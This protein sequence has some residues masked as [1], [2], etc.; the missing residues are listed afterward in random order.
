MSHII[1]V[2]NLVKNYKDHKAVRNV[3]FNVNKGEVFGFLGPNGAGKSTTINIL[4]TIISLSKGEVYLDG[5]DVLT[6][7]DEVRKKIGI[8]FQE[9]TLD[10]RLTARENLLIHA[11]LYDV[12]ENEI[13]SRIDEVLEIV[14]LSDRKNDFV[15]SYSGGM[16]RRLEIARGLMHYPKVLFL[17]EPTT[18]LDPQ[19]R[20]YIWKYLLRL[21]K[22]HDMTIFLT[23][24]YMDEAE[25]CDNIAIID[26]G[27]IVAKGTPIELKEKLAYN[28]VKF[29]S[30]N[31]EETINFIRDNYPYEVFNKNDEILVKVTDLP[32]DFVTSF[33]REYKENIYHLEIKRPTL[34]DVFMNITGHNIRD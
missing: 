27:E 7:Q 25:I 26:E 21:K 18:G 8:I 28:V 34:D 19:T 31:S 9:R 24:H 11:R 5:K 33:I 3:S 30:D 23:T 10:E 14:E 32:T 1:E 13:E 22:E 16:K 17:D 4:C 6:E 2:K 29:K 12:K 20:S 15:S